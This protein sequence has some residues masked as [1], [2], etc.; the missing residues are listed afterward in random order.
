MHF[1][2]A[3]GRPAYV[4]DAE[5]AR[6]LIFNHTGVLVPR[7]EEVDPTPQALEPYA[8]GGSYGGDYPDNYGGGMG[9]FR[10]PGGM[11]VPARG[12]GSDA[13]NLGTWAGSTFPTFGDVSSQ[14]RPRTVT[15]PTSSGGGFDW[16]AIPQL[17]AQTLS[18]IFTARAQASNPTAF[19][20]P[21]S[22]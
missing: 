11:I 14:T 7:P 20:P 22:V 3:N 16:N 6:A 19:T 15:Q 10:M 12:M 21:G 13:F 18:T 17:A 4:D 9:G 2:D 8:A 5:L 1:T